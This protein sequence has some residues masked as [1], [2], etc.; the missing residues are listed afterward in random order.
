MAAHSPGPTS[1]CVWLYMTLSTGLAPSQ[2]RLLGACLALDALPFLWKGPLLYP[3]DPPPSLA[4]VGSGGS[5][6]LVRNPGSE[7]QMRSVIR[8]G[9]GQ[10][11]G[12]VKSA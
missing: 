2:P 1:C 10:K 8:S 12:Q 3:C 6:I 7:G 4:M 5:E 9:E 11:G